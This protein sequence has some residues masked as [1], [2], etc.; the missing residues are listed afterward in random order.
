MLC[1][2]PRRMQYERMYGAKPEEEAARR[3]D[4]RKRGQQLLLYQVEGKTPRTLSPLSLS[5]TDV[6]LVACAH[7]EPEKVA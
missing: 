6:N 5:G 3:I 2:N 1:V 7:K 4:S